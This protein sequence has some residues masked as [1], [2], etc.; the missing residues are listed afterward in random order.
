MEITLTQM[1]AEINR[2]L[3]ARKEHQEAIDSIDSTLDSLR[4]KLNYTEDVVRKENETS[5]S[6]YPEIRNPRF[7]RQ[8]ARSS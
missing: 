4:N 6:G 2:L 3:A 5:F 8:D 7:K 1:L